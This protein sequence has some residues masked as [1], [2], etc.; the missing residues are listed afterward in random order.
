M[1]MRLKMQIKKRKNTNGHW[2]DISEE[3]GDQ[4]LRVA[5]GSSGQDGERIPSCRQGG[6]K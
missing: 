1:R 2:S 5:E 6:K 4:C 3:V